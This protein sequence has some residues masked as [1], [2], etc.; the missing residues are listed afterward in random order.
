MSLLV[1]YFPLEKVARS[2]YDVVKAAVT[3]LLAWTLACVQDSALLEMLNS[4]QYTHFC[5]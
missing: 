3:P 2:N 4:C 5:L 1:F